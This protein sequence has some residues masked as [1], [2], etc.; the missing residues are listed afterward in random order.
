MEWLQ[1][2]TYPR[3]IF[4]TPPWSYHA[5]FYSGRQSNYG[6]SYYAWSAGHNTEE[7]LDE[8][9]RWLSGDLPAEVWTQEARARHVRYLIVNDEF[10]H[11]TDAAMQPPVHTEGLEEVAAFP[12]EGNMVI[13][14]LY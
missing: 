12:E 9:N 8:Q 7:R 11:T 1:A 3:D 4:I 13:Y 2:K 14:R 5:F 10:R 6:H